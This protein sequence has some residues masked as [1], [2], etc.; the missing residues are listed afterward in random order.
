[1]GWG[2]IVRSLMPKKQTVAKPTIIRTTNSYQ[3]YRIWMFCYILRN[4]YYCFRIDDEY[5]KNNQ[6]LDGGIVDDGF[7]ESNGGGGG[8][9]GDNDDDI[10]NVNLDDEEP[11]HPKA[12]IV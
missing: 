4:C 1:M 6:D 10:V 2:H 11:P 3:R 12:E 5:E 9:N 7:Y 8:G